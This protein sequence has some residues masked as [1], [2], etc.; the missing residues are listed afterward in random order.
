MFSIEKTDEPSTEKRQTLEVRRDIQG[1]SK[2]RGCKVDCTH[3][4]ILANSKYFEIRIANTLK[5]TANTSKFHIA[6]TLKKTA[7][8]SRFLKY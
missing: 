2:D 8:T 7:N 6:N 3:L 1:D 5:E 4:K